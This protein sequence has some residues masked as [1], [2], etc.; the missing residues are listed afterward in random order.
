MIVERR[1][2]VAKSGKGGKMKENLIDLFEKNPWTGGNVRIYTS[3][4][5]PFNHVIVESESE[6]LAAF[7]QAQIQFEQGVGEGLFDFDIWHEIEVSASTQMWKLAYERR[8]ED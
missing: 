4:I 3:H 7:E 5:G 2:F 6:S 8:I 1:T